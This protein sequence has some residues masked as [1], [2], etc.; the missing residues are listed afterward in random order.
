M[1]NVGI[2]ISEL[3]I[4]SGATSDDLLLILDKQGDYYRARRISYNT[5]IGS[6]SSENSINN[7]Y[8]S[9]EIDNNS[10]NIDYLSGEID[11]INAQSGI[12]NVTLISG[13]SY[14][15]LTTDVGKT[16][17]MTSL[18]A[19]T[20]IVPSDSFTLYSEIAIAQLGAGTTTVSAANGVL[21]NGI[22]GGSTTM[23]N[24]FG[25]TAVR[26]LSA[27]AWIIF[28]ATGTVS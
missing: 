17:D 11:N 10:T 4:L 25:I 1:P 28:G 26:N 27:D 24:Q 21:L 15:L 6:V 19:N 23:N 7:T 3:D 20:V 8:L 12:A 2:R 5:L 9:G 18:S 16:I 13:T 14:T 22:D